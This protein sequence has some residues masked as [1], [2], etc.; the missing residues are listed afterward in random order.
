MNLFAIPEILLTLLPGVGTALGL[1]VAALVLGLPLGL[2]LAVLA[3]DPSRPLRVTAWCIIEFGR[4][5][6]GLVLLYLIYFGLPQVGL[7]Y[8]AITSAVI[9]F[10]YMTAAYTSEIFAGGLNSISGNQK[11]AVASLGFAPFAAFRL[12]YLPQLLRVA[13]GPLISWGIL[14]L[15]A[16]ALGYAIAV[17]EIMSRAYNYAAI[18]FDYS[19]TFTAA[20]AIYLAIT[21]AV[22]LV[23]RVLLPAREPR[24]REVRSRH[25][26]PL[27]AG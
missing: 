19:T 17:P 4:G 20:G 11:E 5:I 10:T 22:L 2:G 12:I 8:T 9:G 14:L 24:R 16:T 21:Q 6:P 15:Q 25:S 13:R 26:G 7:Y 3:R 23:F 1:T 27:A 18:T